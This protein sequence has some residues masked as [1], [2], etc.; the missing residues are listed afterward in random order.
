[1]RTLATMLA[2]ALALAP[3]GCGTKKGGSGSG[4]S[5]A[6][7]TSP[8]VDVPAQPAG[9]HIMPM[10]PPHDGT[11]VVWSGG[12][13][14]WLAADRAII[15]APDAPEGATTIPL[16]ESH[17]IAATPAGFL[18]IGEQGSHTVHRIAAGAP[19]E[20]FPASL[21]LTGGIVHVFPEAD[22]FWVSARDGLQQV[23]F[24]I[25][26]TR[27]ARGARIKLAGRAPGNEYDVARLADGRFVHLFGGL[28][29]I[30]PSKPAPEELPLPADV[31]SAILVAADGQRIWLARPGEL[32]GL[33]GEPLTVVARAALPSPEHRVH[34]FTA[35]DGHIAAIVRVQ[36]SEGANPKWTAMAF[37]ATGKPVFSQP[38]P[39]QPALTGGHDL[40]VAISTAPTRV[41]AASAGRLIVWEL[42]TSKILLDRGP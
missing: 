5:V 32:V 1:M 35:A 22:R 8:G 13:V 33:E 4:P 18:I 20:S 27:L 25:V 40:S 28:S 31:T 15:V 10:R 19:P 36:A 42:S 30:E 12:R 21:T 29:R 34:S 16:G 7:A 41:A 14:G 17:G 26:G 37:D 9:D 6:Q 2:A 24:R 11:R 3:S 39:W 23:E 38:L